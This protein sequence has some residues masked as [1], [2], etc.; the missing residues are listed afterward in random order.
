MHRYAGRVNRIGAELTETRRLDIPEALV[1]GRTSDDVPVNSTNGR[2]G[3]LQD[4]ATPTSGP[5]RDGQAQVDGEQRVADAQQTAS[6]SEQTLS[7]ADQTRSDSDQTS[8]DREQA[9]ADRDQAASDHDLEESG[10][11]AR[12]HDSS[13][14]IRRRTARE[15]EQTSH[16]RMTAADD[17][18]EIAETRDV[19]G[20]ARDQA[21]DARDLAMAQHD[22]EYLRAES[23]RA[24]TGAEIVLRAAGQRTRA[25]EQRAQA[26]EQRALA[27]QDRRTAA[28]DREQASRERRRSLVDRQTLVR[29]LALAET[30]QLT[31]RDRTRHIR[32]PRALRAT[33]VVSPSDDQDGTCSDTAIPLSGEGP[34]RSG[35]PTVSRWLVDDPHSARGA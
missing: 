5:V 1:A 14:D 35:R 11:S 33:R 18:D 28:D 8:A 17:R 21:A 32:A 23:V 29:Q 27:A 20:L 3:Q 24:V 9:A 2:R 7:D 25:A 10:V 19:A 15:R 31:G 30:D 16:A 34:L 4:G 12:K 26:A 6:D 22:A 13:R